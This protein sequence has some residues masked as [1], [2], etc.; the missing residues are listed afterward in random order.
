MR[1]VQSG[2]PLLHV[3]QVAWQRHQPRQA[4]QPMLPLH[5]PALAHL[6]H[7]AQLPGVSTVPQEDAAGGGEPYAGGGLALFDP[8]SLALCKT[9]QGRLPGLH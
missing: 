6:R 8:A 5:V 9:A 1:A 3:T 7:F 2:Q 4:A